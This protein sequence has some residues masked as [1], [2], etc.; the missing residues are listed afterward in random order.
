MCKHGCLNDCDCG[1]NCPSK[2]AKKNNGKYWLKQA[3]IGYIFISV[4]IFTVIL[5]NNF[6]E[7]VTSLPL[8]PALITLFGVLILFGSILIVLGNEKLINE[9]DMKSIKKFVDK[10]RRKNQKAR[11]KRCH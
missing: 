7:F 10:M 5:A 6:V 9:P 3:G 11:G 8:P 2:K 4:V 1:G